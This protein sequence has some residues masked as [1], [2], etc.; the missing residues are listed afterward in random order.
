MNFLDVKLGNKYDDIRNSIH[1][2]DNFK[3]ETDLDS[4]TIILYRFKFTKVKN[5]VYVAIRIIWIQ[6]STSAIFNQ[7]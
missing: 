2:Y 4:L 7:K 5:Q 6:I 1:N 3:N